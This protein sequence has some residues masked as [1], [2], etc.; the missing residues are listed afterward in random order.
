MLL[1]LP[2][3]GNAV[4]IQITTRRYFCDNRACSR[5][6][7]TE[8]IPTIAAR[9][10]RK[11][12]RLADALEELTLL[13]GGEAAAR[14]AA[15]FGLCVSPDALLDSLKQSGFPPFPT[16]LE[17]LLRKVC[18]NALERVMNFEASIKF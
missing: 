7:F 4:R 14:I 8:P 10:A 17:L 15:A 16:P 6:I 9:Y 18:S 3:Q 12:A 5:R 2:W 11:T 13:V 1:D